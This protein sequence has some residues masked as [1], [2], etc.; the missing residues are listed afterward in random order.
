MAA[1][2]AADALRD[3]RRADTGP[4][5]APILLKLLGLH[6]GAGHLPGTDCIAARWLSLLPISERNGTE[7]RHATVAP[8]RDGRYS[9]SSRRGFASLQ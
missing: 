5:R 2:G 3:F 1:E 6:K 4:A 9:S 7:A 8:Q